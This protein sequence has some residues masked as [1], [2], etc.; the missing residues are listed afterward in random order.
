M[1]L[2][3][4][5]EYTGIRIEIIRSR[6]YKGHR[7]DSLLQPLKTPALI[8][9]RG[10]LMTSRQISELTG[11][12]SYDI[13]ARHKVGKTGEALALPVALY[14]PEGHIGEKYGK[15]TI[16]NVYKQEG[17]LYATCSCECGN[18]VERRLTNIINEKRNQ[19]TISCGCAKRSPKIH[20]M[21]NTK[22]HRAWRHIKER[23][24]N[25]NS[26]SY[27]QYGG[28]GI[29]MCDRWRDSFEN[30]FADMGK[31]PGPEYSIDRIN[32]N[33]DYEPTNCRWADIITQRRNK[34]NTI[35][36]LYDGNYITIG[37]LSDITGIKY[38]TLKEA[39]RRGESL[40]EYIPNLKK[41]LLKKGMV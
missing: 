1:T 21:S 39:Y 34:T 15:L 32:V 27:P 16:L 19:Y 6:Y 40:N 8:P 20:G 11:V 18:I 38:S 2:R 10:E 35:K 14:H 24:L 17:L 31:A 29:K 13:Y 37:E 28:R 7:G 3:Q 23:C 30:F 22:E 33:G 5:A 41:K 9:F 4:I 12:P 25:M 26:K 36:V